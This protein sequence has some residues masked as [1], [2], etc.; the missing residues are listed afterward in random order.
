MSWNMWLS[1]HK[2]VVRRLLSTKI[3]TK[4][5]LNFSAD[6]TKN[7]LI[8]LQE[9][10][11]SLLRISSVNVTKSAVSC[12]FSYIYW[13][14]LWWKTS[15]FFF[16]VS[17]EYTKVCLCEEQVSWKEL[18]IWVEQLSWKHLHISAFTY[19]KLTME[20]PEQCVKSIQ[21]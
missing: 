13:R 20:T 19:S 1:F 3:S 17:W 5:I 11:S 12:G 9:K 7:P 21:S 6:F 18:K 10:W 8:L 2:Y 15:F 16:A 14:N 4:I